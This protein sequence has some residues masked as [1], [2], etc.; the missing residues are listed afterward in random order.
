M[1]RYRVFLASLSKHHSQLYSHHSPTQKVPH[2]RRPKTQLWSQVQHLAG[3]NI[4]LRAFNKFPLFH[5]VAFAP[6]PSTR[7]RPMLAH[8][9]RKF[10]Q[11]FVINLLI[12][13]HLHLRKSAIASAHQSFQATSR[14]SVPVASDYHTANHATDQLPLFTSFHLF[15]LAFATGSS[16]TE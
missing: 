16:H 4:F 12:D 9:Q 7:R 5:L 14:F 15:A 13:K 6:L 3:S 10:A 8:R 2:Y 11:C 1:T